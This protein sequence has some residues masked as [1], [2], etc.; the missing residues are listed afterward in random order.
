MCAKSVS[1]LL[2]LC[3]YPLRLR[4]SLEMLDA[5][6]LFRQTT[7]PAARPSVAV[8]SVRL[9]VSP[10]EAAI[11]RCVFCPRPGRVLVDEPACDGGVGRGCPGE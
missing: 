4:A 8:A 5:F 7:T 1:Y 6:S 10:L 3:F 9:V 11:G 2:L